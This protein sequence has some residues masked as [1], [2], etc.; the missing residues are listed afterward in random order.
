[1]RISRFLAGG[2]ASAAIAVTLSGCVGAP[3]L[4]IYGGLAD[5]CFETSTSDEGFFAVI[6]VTLANDSPRAVILREVRVLQLENATLASLTVVDETSRY[7]AFGVAP[8]GQLTPEQRPLW[9]D[10]VAIDGTV[11][12]AGGSAELLVE[13]RADDYTD[14]A[15]MR[16]LRIKYDDGWFSA[17]SNAD[18]VVGFVPPWAHCGSAAR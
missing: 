11:I 5:R 12:E 10:R 4:T 9:N 7:S 18:A 13:L 14:Y 8:G 2:L 1:M 3:P 17:T 16:G 15:G 6:G